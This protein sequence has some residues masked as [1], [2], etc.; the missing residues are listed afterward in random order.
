V[1]KSRGKLGGGSEAAAAG[2]AYV[3]TVFVGVYATQGRYNVRVSKLKHYY[4]LNHLHY[5][6]TGIPQGGIARP[7]AGGFDSERFRKQWVA[8]SGELGRE[9]KF[10]ILGYVLMPEHFHALIWPAAEANPSQIMQKLEDRTALFILKN[11]RENLGYPWCQKMLAGVT[12]PPTAHPHARFR[13]WQR[14]SYDMNIWSPKKRDEKL[15]YMHNNPVQR[16]LVKHPGDWP[17]SSWR[18]SKASCKAASGFLVGDITTQGVD[19][20][21]NAANSTL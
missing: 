5:L 1:R 13:V 2:G 11:L 19:A 3:P 6:T 15:N 18:F 20:I 8:T 7:S 9:L 12:L 4:G 14:K 10:R 17:W 16:G 21:V